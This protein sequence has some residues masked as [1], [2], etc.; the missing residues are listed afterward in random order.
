MCNRSRIRF[1]SDS[2]KIRRERVSPSCVNETWA[3]VERESR[4]ESS[5]GPMIGPTSARLASAFVSDV[6]DDETFAS[7]HLS[8][9]L[10][11]DRQIGDNGEIKGRE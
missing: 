10:W 2:D 7:R 5:I 11:V 8:G 1:E 6:S 4:M 3:Y 9:Y